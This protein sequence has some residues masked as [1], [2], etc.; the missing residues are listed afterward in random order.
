MEYVDKKYIRDILNELY[1]GSG[2]Y[3]FNEKDYFTIT[4]RNRS[5]SLGE[6]ILTTIF[7]NIAKNSIHSTYGGYIR[8]EGK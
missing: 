7:K 8:E 5:K 3:Y 4:I 6:G 1:E 2:T